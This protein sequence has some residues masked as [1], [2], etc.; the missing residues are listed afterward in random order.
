MDVFCR[1]SLLKGLKMSGKI[2]ACGF[3]YPQARLW[4]KPKSFQQMGKT[5]YPNEQAD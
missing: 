4:L 5:P 1:F 2:N 3:N